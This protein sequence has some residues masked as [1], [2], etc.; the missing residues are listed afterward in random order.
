MLNTILQCFIGLSPTP[1]QSFTVPVP[2]IQEKVLV[3]Q[4]QSSKF[5]VTQK[6]STVFILEVFLGSEEARVY[7]Q[8]TLQTVQQDLSLSFWNREQLVEYMCRLKSA[9]K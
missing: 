4:T 6:N 1:I 3:A 7:S 2:R 8:G 5:Y 9:R